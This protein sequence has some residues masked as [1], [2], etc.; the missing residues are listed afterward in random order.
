MIIYS[1]LTGKQYETVEE[2]VAEEKQLKEQLEREKEAR[3]KERQKLKSDIN[4]TYAA[5]VHGW[6]RYIELLEQAEY[7]VSELEDKA[8]L[9]VEIITDAERTK[10]SNTRS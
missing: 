3:Y 1:E 8:I 6:K 2:C 4:D 7:D 5:L 10:E 9:F